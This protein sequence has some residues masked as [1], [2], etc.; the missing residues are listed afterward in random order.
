MSF[1][2]TL[3]TIGKDIEKGFEVAAPILKAAGG[4][5]PV[6]GPV[7]TEIGDIVTNLENGGHEVDA[8]T[9]QAIFQAVATVS[10][11]K[12]APPATTGGTA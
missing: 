6:V 12:T 2:S 8:A 11:A 3:E 9:L 5:V 1:L 7:L 10:A 4:I